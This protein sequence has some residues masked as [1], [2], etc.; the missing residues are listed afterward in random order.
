MAI[1]PSVDVGQ[2][3]SAETDEI[4]EVV[5]IVEIG[6]IALLGSHLIFENLNTLGMARILHI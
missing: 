3:R 1:Y 4:A 2:F 5:A 6:V